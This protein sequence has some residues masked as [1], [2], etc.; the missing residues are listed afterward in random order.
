MTV[1][2]LKT[3]TSNITDP[4]TQYFISVLKRKRIYKK[5]LKACINSYGENLLLSGASERDHT[6]KGF[7]ERSFIWS[8]TEDGVSF[9]LKVSNYKIRPYK[10]LL[11]NIENHKFYLVKLKNKKEFSSGYVIVQAIKKIALQKG[12]ITNIIR[13]EVEDLSYVGNRPKKRIKEELIK[14]ITLLK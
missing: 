1:K 9:W 8:E 11:Q 5:F 7:I 10:S 14:K 3:E 12:V 4:Y 6:W 2:E 13:L